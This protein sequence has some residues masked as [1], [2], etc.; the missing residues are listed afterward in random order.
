MCDF[1]PNRDSDWESASCYSHDTNAS[2]WNAEG[3][4]NRRPGLEAALDAVEPELWTS[5]NGDRSK[6]R[7]SEIIDSVST[8][9][10]RC[11]QDR[12]QQRLET[13]ERQA[14]S[15]P[16]TSG[17]SDLLGDTK[18]AGAKRVAGQNRRRDR[19]PNDDKSKDGDD[20]GGSHKR[21]R[22]ADK[23][24]LRYACPFLKRFP[25][26]YRNKRHCLGW[27]PSAHRL[28]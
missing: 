13:T 9:L 25:G 26:T 23:D 7:L 22:M 5:R 24:V 8:W 14:E 6:L 11:Q 15:Q 2:D 3:D 17:S 28:K 1:Q 18:G 4:R 16:S 19:C 12:E 10:K 21:S 20:P 27:W